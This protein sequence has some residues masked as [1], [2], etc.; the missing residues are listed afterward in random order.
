MENIQP[1][2][3]SVVKS[4]REFNKAFGILLNDSPSLL[5]EQE[6]VLRYKLMMEELSEYRL[7]CVNG[8]I[9]EVCDAIVDLL[10]VLT[11][12]IVAH[13]LED[14]VQDMFDEVHRSNMS[15]LE[16]GKPVYRHDGKVM[17]GSEYFKPNL[18]QFLDAKL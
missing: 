16:N 13:G 4:V 15:K 5:S 9:V 11:G 1:V 2:M 17:K 3:D 12:M 8:D 7:A 10:Y 18:I 14:V 6:F